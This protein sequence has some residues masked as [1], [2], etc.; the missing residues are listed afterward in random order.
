MV[1]FLL[2]DLKIP[3][4]FVGLEHLDLLI[5]ERN[6]N[7]LRKNLFLYKKKSKHIS[8]KCIY[9]ITLSGIK[10]KIMPVFRY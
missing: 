3:K 9:L 6:L 5:Y 1:N 8:K 4:I 2:K 10:T 7:Q